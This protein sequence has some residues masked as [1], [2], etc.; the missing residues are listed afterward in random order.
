MLTLTM[1]ASAA[2]GSVYFPVLDRNS[3]TDVLK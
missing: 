1:T 3:D 2:I